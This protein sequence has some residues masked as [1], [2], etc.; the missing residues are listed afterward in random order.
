MTGRISRALFLTKPGAA[1]KNKTLK[2]ACFFLRKRYTVRCTYK[3]LL[4]K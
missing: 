2:G 1:A 3:K 4:W